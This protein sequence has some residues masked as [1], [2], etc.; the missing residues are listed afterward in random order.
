MKN[1]LDFC[2]FAVYVCIAIEMIIMI[3]RSSDKINTINGAMMCCMMCRLIE[4]KLG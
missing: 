4:E 1:Y 3:N 2:F